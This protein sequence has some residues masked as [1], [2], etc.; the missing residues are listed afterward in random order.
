MLPQDLMGIAWNSLWAHR[1]R[2]VLSVLGIIIGIASFSLMYS[3]G[4]TARQKT[5]EAI[6]ALGG[7]IFQV[8]APAENNPAKKIS[9]SL[10]DIAAIKKQCPSVLDISPELGD[11]ISYMKDGTMQ[12]HNLK[13]V[14]PSYFTMKKITAGQG[15][16]FSQLDLDYGLHV[17]VLGSTL[18]GEMFPGRD[19]LGQDISINGYLFR[20]IGVLP[21]SDNPEVENIKEY[22]I[23]PLPVTKNFFPNKT[24][25]NLHLHATGTAAAMGEIKQFLFRRFGPDAEFEI[26]SQR[27]LL[28]AQE[29]SFA[30]FG[31]VLWAI[32]GISLVV[33]GIGI[34]NIM[35]VSVTER[36]REIGIRRAI[37][38]TRLE[39]KL[40]FLCEAMLLCLLGGIGGSLLGFAGSKLVSRGFG[41]SPVFSFKLLGL[42]IGIAS[43]L[44]LICGTY[45]AVRAANQDPTVVL[46]Y[47]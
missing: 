38:A 9:F 31:Y 21:D 12:S 18:A 32:G 3:V 15:R 37:G 24:I 10:D 2:T 29:A 35:L 7:D 27:Q 26:Q 36:V 6:K 30:I 34:I 13:A 16:L 40:Q 42:A 43:I 23:T 41:F 47:E 17:C 46:R 39:I 5:M 33:G 1:L 19:P 4:E 22:I 14:M 28:K 8:T 44:G 25:R 20:V 45:P 11:A